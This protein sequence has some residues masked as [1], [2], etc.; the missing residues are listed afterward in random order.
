MRVKIT[1]E[2]LDILIAA[3]KPTAKSGR[4]TRVTDTKSDHVVQFRVTPAEAMRAGETPTQINIAARELF[5]KHFNSATT[6]DRIAT[7]S[8]VA[9]TIAGIALIM[10]AIV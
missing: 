4:H 3:G 10:G 2:Q 8:C 1:Q 6:C 5:L 9:A 7:I